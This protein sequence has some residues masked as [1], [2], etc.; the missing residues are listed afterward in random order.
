MTA[1]LGLDKINRMR[2]MAS[3]DPTLSDRTIASRVGCS[4]DMVRKYARSHAPKVLQPAVNPSPARPERQF[5]EDEDGGVL[6]LHTDRPVK[7]LEDAIRVAEVDTSVWYVERWEVSDYT[8]PMKVEQ[9]QK[10]KVVDG[11]EVLAWAGA[12]PIQ[13][14]QYRVK[15][16]LKRIL[17]RKIHA[18]MQDVFASLR[19]AAPKWPKLPAVSKAKG[20][21]YMALFGLFDVHFGKLAWDQETGNNYDLQIAEK[22]FR[23][24]VED[25]V[26]DSRHRNI[27]K[28]LFPVGNDLLH[29][30]NRHNTTTRGTPQDVDGRFS[31]VLATA[32]RAVIWA[33][34]TMAA[35]APVQVELVPGNHD[36]T[37]A[38]CL[39]H[40]IDA[41]FH[42]TDRVT[43]GLEPKTRKYVV[44]GTNLIGLTHGDLVKPADLPGL[45]P[46]DVPKEWA[47]TTTHEWITGHGH[48]SMKWTTKDTDTVRGTVVRQ[49]RALTRTDLWHHDHGFCG[50]SAAAEILFYGYES[51]YAGHSVVPVRE[52]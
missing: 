7:T 2:E 37:M 4:V 6:S 25:L 40:T 18:A 50:Q 17:P 43:V 21:R 35:V 48:R 42:H 22:L 1:P 41:R 38:E 11:K 20:D 44:F 46:S 32:I 49:L 8:V 47:A 51:G 52:S 10:V 12:K 5:T 15:V 3:A 34:E 24:A 36:R 28:I 14:Q 45:M 27:T 16:F 31:K 30:D 39:C 19:E 26:H 33:V 23:H 9:G 13:T 29:C